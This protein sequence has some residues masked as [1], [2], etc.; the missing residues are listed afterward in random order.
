MSQWF[1]L[2]VAIISE[3]VATSA[4]KASNGFTQLWPSLLVIGGYATAFFFLSLTLRTMPVGMAYAIWSGIGI[5]LVT[6]IAWLVLGQSLD[7]P[8][9]IGLTLIIMGVI[10]LQ[11]FSRSV[12]LHY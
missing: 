11:V 4:L 8:A 1:F 3:V 6:L 2:S 10:I 7:I 12:T 9:I 5:V